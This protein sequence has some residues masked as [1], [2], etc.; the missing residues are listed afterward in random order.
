V[1]SPV[2]WILE[3]I[4]STNARMGISIYGI[5]KEIQKPY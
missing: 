1:R 2:D 3:R 4:I 5:R